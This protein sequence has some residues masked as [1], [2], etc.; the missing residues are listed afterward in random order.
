VYHVRCSERS[1]SEFQPNG[2]VDAEHRLVT[3][4][5]TVDAVLIASQTPGK[6]S[7]PN[8]RAHTRSLSGLPL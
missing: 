1:E 5:A 6:S 4:L 8:S 3:H 7:S 2:L